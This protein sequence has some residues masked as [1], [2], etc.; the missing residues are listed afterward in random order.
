M[1]PLANVIRIAV[2]QRRFAIDPQIEPGER[3]ANLLPLGHHRHV[4]RAGP[5][6]R[7]AIVDVELLPQIG[8]GA[9]DEVLLDASLRGAD[10]DDLAASARSSSAVAVD[11]DDAR[12]RLGVVQHDARRALDGQ[13]AARDERTREQR[14]VVVS[15]NRAVSVF[16][17]ALIF[18]PARVQLVERFAATAAC[19][20]CCSDAAT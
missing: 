18:C 14:R 1:S 20:R 4:V 15:V 12:V 3:F 8:G 6:V 5:I 10:V 2:E 16:I 9:V 13:R 17:A 7:L 11:Q 19:D